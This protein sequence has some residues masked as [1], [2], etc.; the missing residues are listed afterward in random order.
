MPIWLPLQGPL[1]A[2]PKA[3]AVQA[4]ASPG[5]Q[6]VDLG[7]NDWHAK[8]FTDEWFGLR[9]DG[10]VVIDCDN[11]EARDAWLE[12][13][14][15]VCTFTRKTP[16]G[17]HFFYRATVGSPTGPATSVFPKTDIRAGS[18]SQVVFYAPG[19]ED[20]LTAPMTDF[21]PSWLPTQAEVLR[22]AE[23]WS[24]MPEGRGN[25]TMAAIAGTLRRQ[26]MD[27]PTML[28]VLL[29]VNKLTMTRDPMPPEMVNQIALSVSRYDPDPDVDLEVD[30]AEAFGL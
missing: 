24:E 23:E 18:G 25:N 6:G 9:C 4:W 5:Y 10:I 2:K 14:G 1:G 17:W 12:R 16:H 30:E 13:S 21:D 28:R 3:P 20:H 11:E 27:Y 29:Y 26:G 22:D 15:G 7:V 19:Y 8:D